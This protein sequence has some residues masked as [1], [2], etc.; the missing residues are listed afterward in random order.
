MKLSPRGLWSVLKETLSEIGDD[1]V[2]SFSAA[3]AYYTVFSLPPLLVILVGVAGVVFGPDQ[4]QEALTRQV[5]DLAGEGAAGEIRAMIG[6]AGDLGEGLGGKLLGLLVLFLG[7]SGAFGQLQKALN[8]A[9]DVRVE[10]NGGIKGVVLKRLL[11][12][13]M[14]LT[15][16]FLLLVSLAISA[17]ITILSEQASGLLPGGLSAAVWQFINFAVSFGIVTLLFAAIFVVLPDAKIA[18]R[19]V[20]VGAG[21]T[22]LLFTLGKWGIGLYLGRSDP[23]SAFGAAGSLALILVWIYYSALILLAGAEFTQVWARRYGTRIVPEAG[24]VRTDTERP[25][26]Y[27]QA[28]DPAPY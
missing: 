13:G 25:H 22:A 20:W 26:P 12:F 18:W 23:G 24:A 19:D 14:V 6:N 16:A 3:I 17:A 15:I 1:D 21:V 11:S 7:A 5:G 2:A 28:R 8:R 9:W 10:T 4:V 27:A